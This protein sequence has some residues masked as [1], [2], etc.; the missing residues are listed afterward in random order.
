MIKLRI[1]TI[2]LAIGLIGCSSFTNQKKFP[3]LEEECKLS[4]NENSKQCQI[5]ADDDKTLSEKEN[6]MGY[7]YF[8]VEPD[9]LK[10]CD[11]AKYWFE[12]SV[13][14]GNPEALNNLGTMYYVGCEVTKDYKEAEKYFLLA[15]QKGSQQA[16]ANLG[17]LYREGGY[18]IEQ[19]YDKALQWYQ[20]AIKDNPYRAY[21]G[22]ASLYLDQNNYEAAYKYLVQAANLGNPESQYNL[23]YLYFNGIAVPEDKEKAR[24]WFEKAAAGGYEDAN[25]YLN[26]LLGGQAK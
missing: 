22:L 1:L 4:G 23:G 7:I 14:S 24:Y 11:K 26:I 6:L 19:D 18:G 9:E 13:K 2:L 10:E 16:S 21:R 5:V 17:E 8:F 12:K 25:Y 20:L 3:S 15:N